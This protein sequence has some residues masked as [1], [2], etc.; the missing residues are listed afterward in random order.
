[1]QGEGPLCGQRCA[2]V[3]LSRCNLACTWCDTP[4]T[5]DWRR[6]DPAAVTVRAGVGEVAD[7]VGGVGVDLLV[8]TG[9]EPL[10]QQPG[11]GALLDQVSAQ[12]RVQV[13]TNGTR[14][15]EPGLADRVD[16]W[17]VSPKLAN[18]GMP[19]E[20]R[21][22]PAALEALRATGRAAFKFVVSDP[23]V[24]VAEIAALV[25]RYGLGPVWVMPEATTPSAVV[26]G[27]AALLETAAEH[28][29]NLSTRLHVLAGAR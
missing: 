19:I 18:S 28:G 17:V 29:W 2:F 3:R 8:L 22:V 10:L 4:E 25:G 21:L 1:M 14:V 7:W 13:E 27:T 16:L 15:P 6:Y 20:R 11:L 23:A 24:D 12:V 9:G 5:W 26:E